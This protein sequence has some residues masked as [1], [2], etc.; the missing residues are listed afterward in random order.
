MASFGLFLYIVLSMYDRVN[1][2]LIECIDLFIPYL[3]VL[4]LFIINILFQQTT[5]T[6]NVFYNLT[7]CLAFITILVVCLRTIY[8]KNMVLNEIMGYGINFSYFNDFLAFMKVLLYGISIANIFFMFKDKTKIN[9][10]E[11]IA[12]KIKGDKVEVL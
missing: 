9:M 12:K 5:V 2:S 1:K 6:K 7:C 10:N 8:D 4:I 3:L 11:P